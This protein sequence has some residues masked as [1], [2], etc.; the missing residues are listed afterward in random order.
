MKAY[1]VTFTATT[2][3]V[4]KGDE[5]PEENDSLRDRVV[6]EALNR[7]ENFGVENYLCAENAEINE[8]TECPAGEF[9]LDEFNAI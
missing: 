9:E 3:V 8:D 2:R 7:I 1:L 6:A 5:N 4:V